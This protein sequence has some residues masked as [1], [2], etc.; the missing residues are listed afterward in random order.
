MQ[1]LSVNCFGISVSSVLLLFSKKY[2]DNVY[3][4]SIKKQEVLGKCFAPLKVG[5][6]LT[7]VM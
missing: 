6:V 4:P 1:K 3:K 5:H 7:P 2:M